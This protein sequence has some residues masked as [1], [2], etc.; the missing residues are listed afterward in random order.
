MTIDAL[1]SGGKPPK[2]LYTN[3][4]DGTI[5]YGALA[6]AGD[7]S[8]TNYIQ[9]LT[10]SSN[11]D[12]CGYGYGTALFAAFDSTYLGMDLRAENIIAAGDVGSPS[13]AADVAPV[14]S[15]TI[16]A[17]DAPNCIGNKI[18]IEQ[19]KRTP[20]EWNNE[21]PQCWPLVFYRRDFA[22]KVLPPLC[23][24]FVVKIPTNFA[25]VVDN[26][27]TRGWMEIFA[28]K[29]TEN[30]NT[31]QHRLS[32]QLIRES[33]ESGI[34]IYVRLDLFNKRMDGTT[35]SGGGLELLWGMMSEE[36]A[37]VPGNYYDFYLYFDQRVDRS[38]LT[39][40]TK[41]LVIDKSTNA[42]AY[43]DS[44]TGVPTCGYDQASGGRI[45]MCGLYTGGFPSSGT[46]T[47][48]YSGCQ[49]WDSM[50]V[51]LL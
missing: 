29:G 46:I 11:R 1:L 47:M 30:N 51:I 9:S 39:G 18:T 22:S 25:D 12:S 7:T 42:I 43:Q 48:E 44:K 33:G 4:L 2:L 38:D 49:I 23:Y 21:T 13:T 40:V 27:G 19:L 24:R 8:T 5:S 37:I 36:G 41:I 20:A 6:K 14:W 17:T 31:N 50:P 15:K 10:N 32:I 26:P 16:S 3:Y 35:I 28:I 45:Y 34:R